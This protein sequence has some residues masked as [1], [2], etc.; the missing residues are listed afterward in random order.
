ME[1]AEEDEEIDDFLRKLAAEWAALQTEHETV[2]VAAMERQESSSLIPSAKS[3]PVQAGLLLI[4]YFVKDF[5]I[6]Y[7]CVSD[8]TSLWGG[9]GRGL[10]IF[11]VVSR[12]CLR[13]RCDPSQGWGGG[14]KDTTLGDDFLRT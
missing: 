1:N 6:T 13:D 4:F 8:G 14:L 10:T 3:L 11:L 7:F 5:V 12:G 9:G 2:E